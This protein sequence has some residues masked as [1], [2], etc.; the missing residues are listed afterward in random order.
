MREHRSG[1]ASLPQRIQS[2]SEGERFWVLSE[3]PWHAKAAARAAGGA[4]TP[5]R[6]KERL[7]RGYLPPPGLI[8]SRGVIL[9]ASPRRTDGRGERVGSIPGEIQGRLK[10]CDHF[11]L[12]CPRLQMCRPCQTQVLVLPFGQRPVV[13]SRQQRRSVITGCQAI[14]SNSSDA[15]VSRN[16]EPPVLP[17]MWL[18]ATRLRKFCDDFALLGEMPT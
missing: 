15:R 7:A 1:W 5:R 2:S 8:L 10:P 9:E 16:V 11:V 6:P 13:V 4:T 3:F 14:V 18:P 12:D 17:L